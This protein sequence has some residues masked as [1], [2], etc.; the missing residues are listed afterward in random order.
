MDQTSIGHTVS[1]LE[2][3]MGVEVR[4]MEI[5]TIIIIQRR[6]REREDL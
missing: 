4:T 3:Y 5:I 1:Y 6:E 2:Y